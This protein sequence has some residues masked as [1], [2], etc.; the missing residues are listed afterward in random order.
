MTFLILA[1]V[2]SGVIPVVFRAFDTWRVNVFWAIPANYMTCVLVGSLL[3]E[4]ALS[5]A[6]IASQTWIFFAALQ[7]IILA[8]NFYLLAHTAQRVGVAVAALASRLS[9]AI[10]SILAF[11]FYGDSL[12]IAKIAGLLAALLALYLC[13]APYQ[14][15][16]TLNPELFHFLPIT[17]F[18]TF[19]CYFSI[20]KYLQTYYLTDSSYHSYVMSG[21]VFAFLCSIVIGI[22]KGVFSSADFRLRHAVAG[23]FLGVINY[24]AIYALLKVLALEGWES[25]QLFPIYS[26]GVVSVSSILALL[27]FKERLSRMKTIGLMVG[28]AAVALLNRS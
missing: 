20:L 13:T 6:D 16:R 17:L 3:T 21:F 5:L 19:G 2:G 12:T 26:V 10:P 23:I 27:F 8:V 9:V 22:A 7:G 24:V 15:V 14:R 28:L 1:I 4:K 25:S 11:L 18:M